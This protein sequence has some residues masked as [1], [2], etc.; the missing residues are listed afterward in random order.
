MYRCISGKQNMTSRSA[1]VGTTVRRNCNEFSF[2]SGGCKNKSLKWYSILVRVSCYLCLFIIRSFLFTCKCNAW[3]IG[4]TLIAWTEICTRDIS[5][6][7]KKW[8]TNMILY[9]W[10][11]PK[12]LPIEW[13]HERNFTFTMLSQMNSVDPI[14]LK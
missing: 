12:Y 10:N 5:R 3:V 1:L 13:T 9:E 2:I 14:Q 7:I 6:I 4:A 11:K 8:Y